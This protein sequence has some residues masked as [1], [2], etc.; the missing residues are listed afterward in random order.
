VAESSAWGTKQKTLHNLTI[1]GY[2][3]NAAVTSPAD[4]WLALSRGT[5][6]HTADGGRTWHD[7]IPREL[8]NPNDGG[9]GPIQ[10]VDPRHGWLLSFPNLL[11]RTVDGGE[12]WTR[13]VLP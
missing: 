2:V 11:F 3:Y 7:A 6:I 10:F 4:A 8:A 5:L 1:G 9:V 13:I 12:H